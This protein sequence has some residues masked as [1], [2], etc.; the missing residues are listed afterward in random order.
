MRLAFWDRLARRPPSTVR[1]TR[2]FALQMVSGSH[3]GSPSRKTPN[4]GSCFV[5]T[6]GDLEGRVHCV[7]MWVR[8]E[9]D[10]PNSPSTE[11]RSLIFPARTEPRPPLRLH[12]RHSRTITMRLAR[13][14]RAPNQTTWKVALCHDCAKVCGPS[15]CTLDRRERC[16]GKPPLLIACAGLEN[17]VPRTVML[18]YRRG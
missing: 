3:R 1:L 5:T 4:G 8:V 12:F 15:A 6:A 11:A 10:P 13:R 7:P 16:G 9:P 2:R 17:F 14:A 18:R